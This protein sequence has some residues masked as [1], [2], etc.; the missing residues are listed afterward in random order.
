M[1][2]I[3]AHVY[4]LR[5]I[6]HDFYQQPCI[7]IVKNIASATGPTSRLLIGDFVVPE[8][9]RLRSVFDTNQL[10]FGRRLTTFLR[11]AGKCR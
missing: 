2:E 6:L 1:T 5:R 11:L 3:D 9:V 7:E 4:L 8:K 10:T